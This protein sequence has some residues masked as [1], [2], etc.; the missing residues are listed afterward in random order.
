MYNIYDT[1]IYH[2]NHTY[3]IYKYIYG[4]VYNLNV[5]Q[6]NNQRV[7]KNKTAIRILIL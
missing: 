1:I 2:T 6:T 7:N 4:T 5:I 3:I